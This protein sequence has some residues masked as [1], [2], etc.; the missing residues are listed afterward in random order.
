MGSCPNILSLEF[1]LRTT[2]TKRAEEDGQGTAPA[3]GVNPFPGH[4]FRPA[5]LLALKMQLHKPRAS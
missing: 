1:L 4:P 2:E 3:H 5:C